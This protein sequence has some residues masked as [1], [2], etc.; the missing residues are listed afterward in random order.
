M[1]EILFL[2]RAVH[3]LAGA[4]WVGG[5]IMYLF[6]V[7]PALRLAGPAPAVAAQI[8]G[9]FKKLSTLCIW[10]LVLS[11]AYLMFDRLTQTELGLPYIIVLLV[12]LAGA[13]GMIA[14]SAYMGQSALRRL[15][16]QSTRLSRIAPQMLVVLG[17]L[18]FV[19]GAVLNT[20]FEATIAP[21]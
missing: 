9:L 3:I 19:L 14:L 12:K 18:V 7:L 5:S 2:V 8:A 16:K 20:L 17:I 10:V 11:G 21:H 13:L 6:V 4:A 15:A 1:I